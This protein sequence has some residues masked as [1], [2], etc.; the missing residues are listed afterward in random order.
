MYL[1]V[2]L[3]LEVL[4]AHLALIF[5]RIGRVASLMLNQALPIRCHV[6]AII[7]TVTALLVLFLLV[8]SQFW[9]RREAVATNLAN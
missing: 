4:A 8:L 3:T 5:E 1:T 6:A 2:A 9:H 7:A